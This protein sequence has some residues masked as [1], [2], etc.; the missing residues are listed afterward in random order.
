MDV[1]MPDGTV[2][3]GVPDGMSKSQLMAKYSKYSPTGNVPT[4]PL[5][6]F[7]NKATDA[8]TF[9]LNKPVTAAGEA[10]IDYARGKGKFG[11]L[12][13]TRMQQENNVEKT[14]SAQNPY[15]S[16]AGSTAGLIGGMGA[17]LPKAAASTAAKIAPT[18]WDTVKSLAAS[19]RNN[20]LL[21]AGISEANSVANTPGSLQDKTASAYPAGIGGAAIGA[22]VPLVLGSAVA[23]GSALLSKSPP[24][25]AA[26]QKIAQRFAQDNV[27]PEQAEAVLA[28]SP[29]ASL[30]DVGDTNVQSLGKNIFNQPGTA[31]NNARNF[32][33]GRQIQTGTRMQDMV[34]QA[35][36]TNANYYDTANNLVAARQQQ[37]APLY[38]AAYAANPSMQSP[39]LNRILDTPAGSAALKDSVRIMQNNRKQVGMSDPELV[40]QAKLVGSYEPG[41]GG[42]APG[43][44]M[45]TLDNTKKALDLAYKNSGYKDNSILSVKNDLLGEMDRLDSTAA[46]GPNSTNP[47]G[48]LYAQGRAAF[49]S[50]S[51][52][53]DAL[54]SGKNFMKDDAEI[55]TQNLANIDPADKP[56]FQIGAATAL[57]DQSGR[58]PSA[59]L[60][61]VTGPNRN[62]PLLNKL[63]AV[64][65]SQDEYFNFLTATQN[66]ANQRATKNAILGNSS[67]AKQLGENAENATQ[68]PLGLNLGNV[69]DLGRAVT[70]EP[71][72]AVGPI[73]Q[74]GKTLLSKVQTPSPDVANEIGAKLFTSDPAANSATIQAWKQYLAAPPAPFSLSP[75]L[76]ALGAQA[77]AITYGQ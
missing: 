47:N 50:P 72:A 23:G 36:D 34:K 56:F 62:Q 18:A 28:N 75:Q 46:T 32:L 1:Q 4:G 20:A 37:A 26:I 19:T 65:P 77:G 68:A 40:E 61:Q 44:N 14:E 64:F 9:G 49:S 59:F 25:Q 41:S 54:E 42:I 60:S 7:I 29:G 17:A 76:G 48:G 31:S 38:K 53:L 15:A 21:G 66:Q 27:T 71:S 24:A 73:V 3:Q 11:D 63:Q 51:Q 70:G 2:I 12:Y 35:F 8:M 43:L 52:S 57:A 69:W 30:A 5:D 6:T 67:T 13:D 39:E 10:A 58:N 22:A 33:L 55:S 74:A 16:M 45:E